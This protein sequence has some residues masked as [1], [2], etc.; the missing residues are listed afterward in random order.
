LTDAPN[1]IPA[2][3]AADE[4]AEAKPHYRGAEVY[5]SLSVNSVSNISICLRWHRVQRVNRLIYPKII[6]SSF[7]FMEYN[8][9]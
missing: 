2:G 9:W 6:V 5:L 8:I 7:R 4:E 3:V 1:D